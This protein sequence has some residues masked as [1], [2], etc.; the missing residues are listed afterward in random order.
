MAGCNGGRFLPSKGDKVLASLGL[1]EAEGAVYRASLRYPERG[2]DEI[3][4]ACQLDLRDTMAAYETLLQHKLVRQLDG[5]WV[6]ERPDLAVAARLAQEQRELLE[7]Q[8]RLLA[9]RR[10]VNDLVETFVAGALLSDR[11]ADTEQVQGYPAIRA[12]LDEASDKATERVVTISVSVADSSGFPAQLERDRVTVARGVKLCTVWPTG[13]L[14]DPG[15][16]DAMV[17]GREVEE[18]RLL[19]KPPLTLIL[20]D[21]MV[22]VTPV[23]QDDVSRGALFVRSPSLLFALGRLWDLAWEL[24]RPAFTDQ[25]VSDLKERDRL[26]LGLL[27]RG[28]NDEAIARQLQLGLRTVRRDIAQLLDGLGARSR[29]EAGVL[30][31]HRGWL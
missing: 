13:A 1:T 28:L 2:P 15:Y 16:L 26:L 27:G 5:R 30:A 9:S 17:K 31:A 23:D 10:E 4:A 22:G 14:D 6:P 7:R 19:D 11:P 12:G 18:Y 24:A 20:Y 3:A 8:E 29:F 21:A 25:V